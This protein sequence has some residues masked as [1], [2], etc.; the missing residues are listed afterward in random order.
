M[1]S[2]S[3][4]LNKYHNLKVWDHIKKEGKNLDNL[5]KVQSYLKILY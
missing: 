5:L 4:K 3:L 2:R 1:D